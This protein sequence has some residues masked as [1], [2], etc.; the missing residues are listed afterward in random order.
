MTEEILD[1]GE[2]FW[3]IRGSFRI[4]GIVNI[5][6]QCGL[7]RRSDGSFVF[8]DSYTLPDSTLAQVNRI[9]GGPANVAAIINL[10]PFHTIHCEWM[11]RTFPAAK[12]YGTRRHQEKWPSLPWESSRCESGELADHFGDLLEFSLP[13]GVALVCD[14]EAVHFSSVLAYHRASR[15]IHVDDTLSYLTAPFPVSLLPVTGRLDFHPTL[16]KALE[17][18]AG[19]A[20]E[21]RDWAIELGVDW[22]DAVRVATAHNSV[23]E[24]ERGQFPELLGAA[25]GRVSSVLDAHRRQYT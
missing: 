25:L 20:D 18:R 11:H 1:C 12:L 3:S 10:H 21:F 16:A 5:G 22:S 23:V 14:D 17:P 9:T 6:T 24:M 15:T 8:L 7:I 4:G 19:A 2:G 13:R